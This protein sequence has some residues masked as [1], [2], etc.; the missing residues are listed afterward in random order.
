MVCATFHHTEWQ[1]CLS[2]LQKDLGL[3]Q[4]S[5]LAVTERLYKYIYIYLLVARRIACLEY[6]LIYLSSLWPGEPTNISSCE[7][8]IVT[9]TDS[10][11]ALLQQ[12][13]RRAERGFLGTA[14][15]GAG[16]LC[17]GASSC[18]QQSGHAA[19]AVL[20]VGQRR[21]R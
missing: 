2:R 4:W 14:H 18:H 15:R 16:R 5:L 9:F 17:T 12:E 10:S 13:V 7:A 6:I 8:E 20:R 11:T 21:R 1:A 19:A 3:G